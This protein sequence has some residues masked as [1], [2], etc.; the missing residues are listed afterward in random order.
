MRYIDANGLR[1]AALE[2]GNPH[3][4]LALL[5]HGF[6]D[7]PDTWQHMLTP[8]ASA[9]FHVVA[10]YMRGY[11]PTEAPPGNAT[12]HD[13]AMDALGLIDAAGHDRAGLLVGHDW[14]AATAYLAATVKPE[15]IQRLVTVALP[16]PSAVGLTPRLLWAGRHFVSLRLPGA[17]YR[18]RRRNFALVDTYYRRWSPQWRIR[19]EDT[20]AVKSVFSNPASLRAAIGYYRGT[21]L[22]GRIEAF[23]GRKI[24]MPTLTVAGP[25][26]PGP[27][28]DSYDQARRKFSGPYRVESLPGGHFVHRES[29]DAFRDLVLEFVNSSG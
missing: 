22:G 14:G 23:R 3:R 19:P 2:A 9:G 17:A 21:P 28:L 4:P 24:P 11:S 16:H 18:L 20:A 13:L 27:A 10:P 5:L 26:D 1:F 7:T 8:L 29:P 15:K 25:D 6:P 12:L